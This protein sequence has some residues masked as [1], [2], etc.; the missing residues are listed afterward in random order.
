[1]TPIA[2][3]PPRRALLAALLAAPALVRRAHAAGFP[4]R[5][6]R[7]LV[8]FSPGGAV[9]LVARILADS[10]R[11]ILGQT[12]V[13]ENRSGAS[14]LI[15]AEAVAKSPP[16]GH[17]LNVVAMSAYTILPQLPGYRMP[18]DMDRDL[19]PV[20]NVAG[21]LNALIAGPRTPYRNIPE[22]IAHAK[23]K[24]D[25]VTYASTGNGTSQHLAAELFSRQAGIRMTH[26]PYRGGSNAIVDIA[27]GR[28][29][30]MFGNFPEFIG[31]IR[32]GSLRL[33]AFAGTA[34]SP[35]FPDTPLIRDT[36]PG[37]AISNWLGL[38]GPSGLP[39][40]VVATWDAALRRAAADATL[41]RRLTENGIEVLAQDQAT[42][43]A[44]IAAD[45]A[46]WGEV[47]RVAGIRAE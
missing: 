21:V 24:P 10:L 12:V 31:Q 8:G 39:A 28:V 26:V 18:V 33:L 27:A 7:L 29:D 41:Q 45:R 1:M 46:R 14:G 37:Y 13:V 19:T 15:A 4:E 16:D 30:I 5:D 32:D 47:I 44:T 6:I 22:L 11:P 20:G 9:D 35:L 43:R 38:A 25:E 2:G 36:L 42:F 17:V 40:P 23:S 3:T 34:A